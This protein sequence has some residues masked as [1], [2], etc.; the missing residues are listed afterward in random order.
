MNEL[1]LVIFTVLV[2]GA[3][4]LFLC[5]GLVSILFPKTGE[6]AMN[7]A[8]VATMVMFGIGATAAIFHLGTP[9]RAFNVLNGVSHSSPLSL[10]IVALSLFGA[11]AVAYTGMRLFNLQPAL[12]K[13]LLPVAMVLGLVLVYAIAQVYTLST[14][15]TWDSGWTLFQFLMTAGVIGPVGAMTLL[16][17]QSASAGHYQKMADRGLATFGLMMLVV[18]VTCF[19]GFVVYLGGLTLHSNPLAMMDYHSTLML[20][21]VALMMVGVICAAV[22]ATRGNHQVTGVAALCFLLV[23]VAEVMGRIFFYDIHISASAGM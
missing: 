14:V 21:R 4:G 22:S 12:R 7:K 6:Q 16:R 1:P 15:P 10:E 8:F 11:S 2:Q 17:W 20:A 3:V 19:V 18:A 23:V 13:V 5:L 9:V